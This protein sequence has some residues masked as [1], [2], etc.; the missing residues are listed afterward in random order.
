MK[1]IIKIFLSIIL[2]FS[3]SSCDNKKKEKFMIKANE[4]ITEL[5][6]LSSEELKEKIQ[7]E[8][9]FILLVLISSCSS[10]E[11]FKQN[12][13]NPYLANSK[14]TLYNISLF[15][16]DTSENFENKP[17]CKVSPS[18]VIYNK[19]K[20]VKTYDYT[21]NPEVFKEL[22]TFEKEIY[23]YCVEPR[24]IETSEELLDVKISNN[25]TFML[26]IGWNKCG[27]CAL[28]SSEILDTYLLENE[29]KMYYLE[30][31]KYRSVKPSQEPILSDN[32]TQE[33]LL[34]KQNWDNWINFASK[35]GFVSYRNGK[36]PVL[37]YYE[38]GQIKEFLVYHNDVIENNVVTESFFVDLIG[39]NVDDSQLISIHNEKTI[40][41]L[42]KYLK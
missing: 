9:S 36:V 14:A 10:C 27:D 42:N 2:L 6:L 40:D 37:I 13:I 41:F 30:S 35:Y 20:I 12:V 32:P 15:E 22:N 38:A 29:V 16:L 19:G 18:L 8:D 23:N 11:L 39:K 1:K 25:E 31:D 34:E 7:W 26:Y 3:I 33:E 17:K 28:L 5:I 24:L 4:E 21:N